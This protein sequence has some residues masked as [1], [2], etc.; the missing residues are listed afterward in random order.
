M[1]EEVQDNEEVVIDD[2]GEQEALYGDDNL[3]SQ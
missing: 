2:E 3:N 1:F